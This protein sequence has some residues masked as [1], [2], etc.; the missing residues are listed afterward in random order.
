MAYKIFKFLLH[1]FDSQISYPCN[2]HAEAFCE[3]FK[4]KCRN[5]GSEQKSSPAQMDTVV[6]PVFS[7]HLLLCMKFRIII[8]ALLRTFIYNFSSFMTSFPTGIPLKKHIDIFFFVKYINPTFSLVIIGPPSFGSQ[9]K[10]HL[11]LHWI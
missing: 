7:F 9:P 4:I 8:S 2:V 5:I 3:K 1:T 11:P 6:S 10:L